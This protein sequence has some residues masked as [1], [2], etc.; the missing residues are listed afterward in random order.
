VASEAA[1]G[2]DAPATGASRIFG[3]PTLVIGEET[4]WGL[5]GFD[6]ALDYLRDPGGF[7]DDEMKRLEQLPVGVV[8]GK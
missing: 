8:R 2:H 5:D 4:F 6:M 3:V 7:A 1:W